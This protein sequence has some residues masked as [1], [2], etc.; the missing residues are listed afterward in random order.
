MSQINAAQLRFILTLSFYRYLHFLSDFFL[1]VFR[2]FYA[3]LISS[4]F[5]EMTKTWNAWWR[6]QTFSCI[7]KQNRTEQSA[8]EFDLTLALSNLASPARWKSISQDLKRN[9]KPHSVYMTNVWKPVQK[10]LV[11]ILYTSFVPYV[12]SIALCHTTI[13]T[14]LEERYRMWNFS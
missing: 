9:R 12:C 4:T 5:T 3:F 11:T 14:K 10:Y 7:K 1:S 13:R 2:I 6:Q 8:C